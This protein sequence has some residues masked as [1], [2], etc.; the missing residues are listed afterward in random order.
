MIKLEESEK[1]VLEEEA[2]VCRF[3]SYLWFFVSAFYSPPVIVFMVG[4]WDFTLE[5]INAGGVEL[6]YLA[7]FFC[8][9]WAVYVDASFYKPDQLL[10]GCVVCDFR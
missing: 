10:F 6:A 7:Y 2:L 1:L 3:H 8:F 9:V 5:I 4:K